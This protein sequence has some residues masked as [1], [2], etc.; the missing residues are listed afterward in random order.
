MKRMFAYM[1]VAA[2][3]LALA[4]VEARA[5]RMGRMFAA[6][7]NDG[8]G[9]HGSIDL[10]VRRVTVTPAV[11]H[12]GDLVRVEAVIEN[13]GEGYGTITARVY[14]NGKPVASHLMTYDTGDGPN[15]LYRESFVWN[16]AGARPGEY[17][18]RAEAVDWN[19]SSPFDNS[20]DVDRPVTLLPAGAPFPTGQA[21]GG[22]AVA[23]DPRWTPPRGFSPAAKGGGY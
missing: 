11:A 22:E 14:A 17:R 20:L 4:G 7:G 12:V 15:A 19:D 9:S 21:G 13:R 3:L 10:I 18:I 1:A 5:G 23:V 6:M 2:L 16:T 8:G